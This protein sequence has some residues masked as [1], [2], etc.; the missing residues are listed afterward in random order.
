MPFRQLVH[1]DGGEAQPRR[2]RLFGL[3]ERQ[4]L[5]APDAAEPL[6]SAEG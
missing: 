1:K 4:S 5:S 6:L 3:T 2:L